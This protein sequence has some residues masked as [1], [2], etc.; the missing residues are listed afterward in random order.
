MSEDRRVRWSVWKHIPDVNVL[1]AV[2]LSLNIDPQKIRTH[3][4]SW[5]TGE[6]VV[7]EAEEFHDRLQ[8]LKA[9]LTYTGD[10]EI[11]SMQLGGGLGTK[12]TVTSFARWASSL[13]WIIP[14]E[15]RELGANVERAP[16]VPPTPDAPL[17]TKERDTLLILIAALCRHGGIDWN[18]RGIASAI[19]L[20]TEQLGARVNDDTIRDVLKDISEALRRRTSK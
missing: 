6:A 11:T 12:I 5:M 7:I 2:A 20:L 8:I 1:Q 16:L 18:Q 9:N 19:E 17:K 14:D 15:L 10:L 3:G 13:G 4:Q